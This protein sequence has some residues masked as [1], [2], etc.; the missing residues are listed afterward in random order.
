MLGHAAGTAIGQAP[1]QQRFE[2]V[3]LLLGD[4]LEDGSI[5]KL[6]CEEGAELFP[7]DY[8]ADLYAD[9]VRG[10]PTVAARVVATTML[11]QAHEGVSDR[12][13]KTDSASIC[14]GKPRPGSPPPTNPS[15][16]RCCA[17]CETASAPLTDRVVS[18]RTPWCAPSRRAS[19]P[20]AF[21]SSTRPRCSTPWPPRT[22]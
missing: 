16:T 4:R 12:E 21:A 6:L 7:D 5:Y 18:L 19:S 10:R 11:L 15:T 22:R 8:F 2:D 20:G 9:S 1:T 13:A 17:G 3:A 14:G